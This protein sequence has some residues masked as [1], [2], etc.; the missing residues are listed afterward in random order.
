MSCDPS[1]SRRRKSRRN[2]KSGDWA[3]GTP[4]SGVFN[5]V[6]SMTIL[7][8]LISFFFIL[9]LCISVLNLYFTLSNNVFLH[10]REDDS[11]SKLQTCTIFIAWEF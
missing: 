2:R 6:A 5:K 7:G 9:H 8:A 1:G 10:V 4:G 11:P 3:A